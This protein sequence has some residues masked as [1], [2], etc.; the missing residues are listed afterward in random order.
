MASGGATNTAVSIP[1]G[2][3]SRAGLAV[4]GGGILVRCVGRA[5]TGEGLV[6]PHMRGRA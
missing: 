6:V 2:H 3:V 1:E 4:L 5:S